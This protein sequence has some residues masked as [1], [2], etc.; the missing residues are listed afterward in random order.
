[1]EQISMETIS[2]YIKD[3]K[4]TGSCQ[5][6]FMKGKSGLSN[7]VAFYYDVN[8]LIHEGRAVDVVYLDF[9]KSFDTVSHNILV[10][11]LTK[12]GQSKWTARWIENWLK[13]QAC[14]EGC[15]QWHKVQLEASC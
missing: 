8:S 13:G 9:R 7:S 14:A 15:G 5:H 12:Y 1:M 4:T 11:K 6:G 10:D 2:K 3:K